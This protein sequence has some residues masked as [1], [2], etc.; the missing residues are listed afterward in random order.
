MHRDTILKLLV[1]AGLKAERVM[2]TQI[3]NV[4]VADVEVDEVWNFIGK[5]QK[6]LRPEDDQELGDCYV[7]V[8]IERTSKLVL[9][10][11]IGKRNQSTTDAFIEGIRDAIAPGR[12]Q[13]TSDGF[14]PYKTERLWCIRICR[15]R[16]ASGS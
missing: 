4:K 7:F 13:I 11:A 1:T 14:Q 2:A 9:N 16:S 10:V 3:R 15:H 5:K 8:A 6:R 12:F